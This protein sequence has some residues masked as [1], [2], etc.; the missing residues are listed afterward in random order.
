MVVIPAQAG[1]HSLPSHNR[2]PAISDFLFDS[3]VHTLFLIVGHSD[4][5]GSPLCDAKIK[6]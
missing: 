5:E 4:M 2:N 1:I 3:Y 6:A